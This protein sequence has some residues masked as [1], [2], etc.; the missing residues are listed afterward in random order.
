MSLSGSDPTIS[1]ASVDRPAQWAEAGIGPGWRFKFFA[2]MMRWGGKARG[3][4]LANFAAVW[5][6]AFYPAI[7]R[8]LSPYLSRRFPKH[9]SVLQKWFDTF[10]IVQAY[11]TTLVDMLV[12]S[13]YGR[14]AFETVS[15]DHERFLQIASQPR[16]FVLVL[17]HVGC[18]QIG[19]STLGELKKSVAVVMIP[20][21]GTMV[22]KAPYR[23]IDP[24]GGLGASMEMSEA[25]LKGEV[26]AVMGDR[27]FGGDQTTAAV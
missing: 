4:H 2:S 24:R 19:M 16:G 15:R 6:A 23:V 18:W 26:V 9:R 10:R 14:E 5:Y 3:Y 22:G 12:L 17:A 20:E 7:R 25:L 21:P 1:H 11:G 8:R 27:V 13:M